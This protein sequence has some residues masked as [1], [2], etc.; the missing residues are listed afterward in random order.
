M[1]IIDGMMWGENHGFER[2]V[3][4]ATSEAERS[5][6]SYIHPEDRRVGMPRRDR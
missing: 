6:R 3:A 2:G 4:R 1:D 5:S